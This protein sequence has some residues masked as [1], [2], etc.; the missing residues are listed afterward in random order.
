MIVAVVDTGVR[1]DH[2]DLQGQLVA[3][4]D[5]IRDATRARDGNGIDPDPND[6]GDLGSGA[7]S[8]FHGTHVAGTIAAATN[9]GIGVAGIAFGAKV[10][11]VRVLGRNGGTLLRRDAGRA[12][13]GRAAERLVDRAP[14][15]ARTSSTCR[16]AAAASTRAFQD[17]IDAAR[18]AGVIVVAA[19]GNDGDQRALV[20][21]VL[22]RRGV[23]R[24][25][26]I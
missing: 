15:S 1:L 2:P 6:P 13:R 10:M 26:W 17:V 16:S 21:R 8:S 7:G 24:R 19:A 23:G 12:L 25:R 18:A 9:N 5:F 14:R 4:Y 22:C 20:P 11:P 3:G